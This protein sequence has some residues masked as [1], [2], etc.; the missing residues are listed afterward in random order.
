[1]PLQYVTVNK[2]DLRALRVERLRLLELDHAR[3]L[4]SLEENPQDA[5]SLRDIVDIERRIILHRD[6]LMPQKD[7]DTEV[8]DGEGTDDPSRD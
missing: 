4:L 8:P 1:M 5:Q 2:A 6:I 3:C 7:E